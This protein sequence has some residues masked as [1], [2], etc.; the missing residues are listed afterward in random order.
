MRCSVFRDVEC[1]QTIDADQE[2]MTNLF[3]C[4]AFLTFRRYRKGSSRQQKRESKHD[5]AF[6]H[7][8]APLSAKAE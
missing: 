7:G 3:L 4:P 8:G 6:S 5:T 2:N 1:V